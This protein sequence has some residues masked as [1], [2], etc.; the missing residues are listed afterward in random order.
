MHQK[1]KT[2]SFYV[3]THTELWVEFL[4]EYFDGE[5]RLSIRTMYLPYYGN[6]VLLRRMISTA[7]KYTETR[8]WWQMKDK[9]FRVLK[10]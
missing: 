2:T 10:R 7:R 3:V 6:V 4:W 5:V 9:G 1:A 8:E